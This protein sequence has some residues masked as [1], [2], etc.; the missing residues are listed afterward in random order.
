MYSWRWKIFF[1]RETWKKTLF[2]D[3]FRKKTKSYKGGT[4]RLNARYSPACVAGVYRYSPACVAGVYLITF[5]IRNLMQC[6]QRI[7]TTR[8]NQI[9]HPQPLYLFLLYDLTH[10]VLYLYSVAG[11]RSDQG[12]QGTPYPPPPARSPSLLN[13]L[14]AGRGA[15]KRRAPMLSRYCSTVSLYIHYESY[16]RRKG[17]HRSS[18]LVGGRTWMSH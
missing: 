13:N 11:T 10:V 7:P 9:H 5:C 12:W 14:L 15:T 2:L 17:R 18:L 8:V 16:G 1:R 6:S 4:V 3:F